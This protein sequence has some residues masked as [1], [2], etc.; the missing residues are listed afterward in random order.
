MVFVFI[1]TLI[2]KDLYKELEEDEGE[3]EVEMD[4]FIFVSFI[5]PFL[6]QC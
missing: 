2:V 5:I 6:S 3:E 4:K 1:Y